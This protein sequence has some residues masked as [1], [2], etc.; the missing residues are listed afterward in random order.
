MSIE[1]A[2]DTSGPPSEIA[3][4]PGGE[5]TS[6]EP[7]C[8]AE[9]ETPPSCPPPLAWQDVLAEFRNQ[10]E[11]FEFTGSDG[12]TVRGQV[13]GEGPPLYILNGL[14]ATPEL[15]CLAVWLLRE[16]FR[17]VV[18]DYPE[19]ATSLS[20]LAS[21]LFTA[22]DGLGDR[23]FDLF[24]SSF[25]SA[26]AMEILTNDASRIRHAV[27]QGPVN[28]IRLGFLERLA[29]RA[30]MFSPGR[31]RHIPFF[32]AALQNNH[33]LWF[34]PFD[35]TRWHFMALNVGSVKISTVARRLRMLNRLDWT[36]RLA[37]IKTPTFIVSSEGDA[38]RHHEAAKLF[39]S[40]IP[41]TKNERIPNCGH[42]PFVTHPHRL[43]KLIGPFLRDEEPA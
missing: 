9:P 17:C 38:T 16:E 12:L 31:M 7:P 37:G 43:A 36:E 18:I 10:S 22:A 34:P 35:E 26:V 21:S 20:E 1:N 15:F 30:A 14:S 40:Q 4:P 2:S 27:L 29:T 11:T 32:K 19:E 42:V 5:T 23:E 24:A 25:S 28:G 6:V 33:R 13:L 41:G 8:A 3:S 39:A